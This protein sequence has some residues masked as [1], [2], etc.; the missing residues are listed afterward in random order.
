M[1]AIK[2][3]RNYIKLVLQFRTYGV[4]IEAAVRLQLMIFH[5]N[6]R[7]MCSI[8]KYIRH[9]LK[10]EGTQFQYQTQNQIKRMQQ[11]TTIP[12]TTNRTLK[13]YFS[14]QRYILCRAVFIRIYTRANTR[15][16]MQYYHSAL[17]VS[18]EQFIW[19][20]HLSAYGDEVLFDRKASGNIKPEKSNPVPY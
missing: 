15:T 18:C 9:I 7:N 1:F 6:E 3:N 20:F 19:F 5:L 11:L 10:S 8:L 13:K 17:I 14:P 12:T 16:Q 4:L 2:T